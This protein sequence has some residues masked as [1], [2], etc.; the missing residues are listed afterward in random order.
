MT[1]AQKIRKKIIDLEARQI[2]PLREI[3]LAQNVEMNQERLVDL[4]VEI[5]ALRGKLA[6]L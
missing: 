5:V 6:T 3:A 4:E 2:R 1:A